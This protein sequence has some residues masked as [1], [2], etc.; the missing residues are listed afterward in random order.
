MNSPQ[1]Y[2]ANERTFLAWVRTYIAVLQWFL[3]LLFQELMLVSSFW[4]M[5]L[6]R[7]NSMQAHLQ[8]SLQDCKPSCYTYLLIITIGCF[9]YLLL[10]A[11]ASRVFSF[12]WNF[13]PAKPSQVFVISFVS[14]TKGRAMIK[15]GLKKIFC[16][17]CLFR[18]SQPISLSVRF[19]VCNL[20]CSQ[21]YRPKKE[22]IPI[23]NSTILVKVKIHFS[24]W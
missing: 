16:Y 13:Q 2:L 6:D 10:S 23:Y 15:Y 14:I 5:N 4:L 8:E 7:E 21:S 24:L 3:E 1:E 12:R 18:D 11:G 17:N 9:L 19:I 20:I 22:L